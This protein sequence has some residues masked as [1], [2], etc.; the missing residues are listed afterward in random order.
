[1]KEKG[2]I[3]VSI[4]NKLPIS[5][6]AKLYKKAAPLGNSEA[7]VLLAQCYLSGYGVEKNYQ[8]AAELL[9][10]AVNAGSK[11]A[12]CKLADCYYNG[13]GV[14]RDYETA[15]ELY[16]KAA[17]VGGSLSKE[18]A[19]Y[20]LGE[21]YY[22]GHGTYRDFQSA[23]DWYEMAA[24]LGNPNA[25][26]KVGDCYY[27]GT[28]VTHDYE[29]ATYFFEKAKSCGQCDYKKLGNS[30]FQLLKRQ[31]KE[32][33]KNEAKIR[34]LFMSTVQYFK[35]LGDSERCGDV[36]LY[37]GNVQSDKQSKEVYSK[38]AQEYYTKANTP[39]SK[40]K[41]GDLYLYRMRYNFGYGDEYEKAKKAYNEFAE[42]NPSLATERK[43]LL[44]RFYNRDCELN[45]YLDG[46]KLTRYR[47]M[48]YINKVIN[49]L[50]S[51]YPK[52][53]VKYIDNI[54]ELPVDKIDTDLYGAVFIKPKENYDKK[55]H[56]IYSIGDYI[57]CVNKLK[58]MLQD[59]PDVN[60]DRSNE[61]AVIYEISKRI[62]LSAVYD[63]SEDNDKYTIRNMIGVLSEGI[64]VCAGYTETLRNALA[65]KG[66]QSIYVGSK[67]VY[68]KENGQSIGHAYLQVNVKEGWRYLDLTWDRDKF[69]TGR[70]LKWFLVPEDEFC[71][72]DAHR[73]GK[74]QK[75]NDTEAF[76]GI[77]FDESQSKN[78]ETPKKM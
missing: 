56:T 41:L 4:A 13:Y 53:I 7:Q 38:I 15:F 62:A 25:Y 35:I 70:P 46:L 58:K 22:N 45:E 49:E 27:N 18:E 30:Y 51:S 2:R 65:L 14:E 37:Y 34:Q 29:K 6:A 17:E 3:I 75:I 36:Y 66:I 5:I 73:A 71:V 8:K 61:Q 43:E 69:V 47:D 42:D 76:Y 74:G 64:T 28:G 20:K 11:T 33:P 72:V 67:T 39:S 24:K 40:L 9:G 57:V 60:A 50:W 26:T 44:D 31:V 16:Q 55:A 48:S 32:E 59:I 12:I 23:I 19:Y 1:M 77:P 52:K 78:I 54:S 63:N 10:K 21:C 68:T